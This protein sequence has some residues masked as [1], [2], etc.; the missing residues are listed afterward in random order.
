MTQQRLMRK[1]SYRRPD[2]P[3]G[4]PVAAPNGVILGYLEGTVLKRRLRREHMLRVPAAWTI[5][6]EAFD[7]LRAAHT[8]HKILILVTDA[9]IMQGEPSGYAIDIE[10]WDTH[11]GEIDRGKFR[12]YF[13]VLKWWRTW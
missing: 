8:I 9:R 7:K 5:N 12:Q 2:P 1:Q 4:M 6:K 10:D 3:A 13:V 11:V